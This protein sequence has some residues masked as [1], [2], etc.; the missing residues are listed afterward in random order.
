[1]D[2]FAEKYSGRILE[3]Y[4]VYTKDLKR[5]QDIMMIPVYMLPFLK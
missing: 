2:A 1:L 4:L 5:D 3:K